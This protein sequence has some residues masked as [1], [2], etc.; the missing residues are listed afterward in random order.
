MR[1]LALI[2]VLAILIA[3]CGATGSTA[4]AP[5][6]SPVR[7]ALPIPTATLTAT[8]A[9]TP[10][11]TPIPRPS[12]S[13]KIVAGWPKVSRGGVTMTGR[14]VEEETITYNAP[15]VRVK[16]TGLAPG[17]V[18]S[19]SGT[20]TYDSELRCGPLLS[21]CTGEAPHTG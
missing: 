10:A 16:V 9:V 1:H 18:V 3:G 20:G 12:P 2:S 14:D 5:A 13:P 6:S 11:A 7:T 19:L 21:G 17:E 8:P 4:S 15:V